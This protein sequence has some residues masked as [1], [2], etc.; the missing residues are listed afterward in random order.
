MAQLSSGAAEVILLPKEW[1]R[2]M[3]GRDKAQDKLCGVSKRQRLL[4][5]LNGKVDD[6]WRHCQEAGQA[7]NCSQ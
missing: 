1:K 5:A 7:K 3:E 4:Q 2:R 6:L